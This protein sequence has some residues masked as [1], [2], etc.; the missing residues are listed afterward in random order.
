MASFWDRNDLAQDENHPNSED[1]EYILRTLEGYDPAVHE[2]IKVT[3][4]NRI[5]DWKLVVYDTLPTWVSPQ[6]RVA[7]A[8][9]AAHSFL[10]TSIQGGSQAIEDGVTI[11]VCLQLAGKEKIPLAM[12]AY[13][14]IRYDRV[15]A[16]QATGVSTRD[17]WHK[18]DFANTVRSNPESVRLPRHEFLLNFDA[19]KEAYLR[20][21]EV[22]KELKS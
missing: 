7:L 10:P 20:F 8:G 2:L 22:A 15:K 11:A 14:K 1:K 9:D 12:R 13:E 5:Y 18:A 4:P 16:A 19:E 3:P 21:E 6:G 17:R